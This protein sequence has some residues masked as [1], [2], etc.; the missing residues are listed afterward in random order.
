MLEPRRSRYLR[1][2]GIDSYVPRVILPGAR[3]S[4]ACE[5]E[6]PPAPE[7]LASVALE[8]PLAEPQDMA[9]EPLNAVAQSAIEASPE[10]QVARSRAPEID[11]QPAARRAEQ[12]PAASTPKSADIA[13]EAVPKIALAIAVGGGIL[14]VDDAP[15][16]LPERGELQRLLGNILFSLRSEGGTPALDVFLWPMLK[17][18]QLDRSAAAARET[19][20]AHIQNQI[21][22]NTVHTVLLLGGA[23][24]EW[25]EIDTSGL[26]C[27]HSVSALECL[28]APGN[29]RQLWQDIRHLAAVH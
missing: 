9:A 28:R 15:A 29:K 27:V 20:A 4:V 17:Q 5:W 6:V 8:P 26:R 3:P 2:L 12:A 7:S 16:N 25:V 11:L 19:L 23:A 14:V 24:R 10:R 1:A 18:P 21:Q 13:A 22:R